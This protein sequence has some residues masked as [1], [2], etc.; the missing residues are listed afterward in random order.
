M[1]WK[2]GVQVCGIY[3]YIWSKMKLLWLY[4]LKLEQT[5][6]NLAWCH[7]VPTEEVWGWE[8]SY[9]RLG[10]CVSWTCSRE[11]GEG[12]VLLEVHVY[13]FGRIVVGKFKCGKMGD[14]QRKK[15]FINNSV[16]VLIPFNK[17]HQVLLKL[18]VF[19]VGVGG[20]SVGEK[21]SYLQKWEFSSKRKNNLWGGFSESIGILFIFWRG[22]GGF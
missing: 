16:E 1:L 13:L 10:S 19:G 18:P 20:S 4:N 7:L 17:E 5:M 6:R 3:S 11:V 15:F 22:F 21:W 2:R 8:I 9:W 14:H 12:E